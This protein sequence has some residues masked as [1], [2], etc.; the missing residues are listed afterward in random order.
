MAFPSRCCFRV[1]RMLGRAQQLA[2]GG[3]AAVLL[4]VGLLALRAADGLHAT[5]RWL[6]GRKPRVLAGVLGRTG[7]QDRRAWVPWIGLICGLGRIVGHVTRLRDRAGGAARRRGI[8]VGWSGRRHASEEARA[9]P[10]SPSWGV[11][12]ATQTQA[13]GKSRRAAGAA[14]RSAWQ[15]A[16]VTGRPQGGFTPSATPSPWRVVPQRHISAPSSPSRVARPGDAWC[17]SCV[18]V[19]LRSS[20]CLASA[21]WP[22]QP[23]L[24]PRW[25]RPSAR[26]SPSR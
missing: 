24:Q 17:R 3:R 22:F 21:S 1:P 9:M 18:E 7:L 26:C 15:L 11:A 25:P 6:H 19:L 4:C 13:R 23:L 10:A 5:G 14:S 16:R 2:H 12:A 20:A 8:G